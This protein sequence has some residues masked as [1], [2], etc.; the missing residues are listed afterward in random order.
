MPLEA[1]ARKVRRIALIV[2]L[3]TAASQ[4]ALTQKS[5]VTGAWTVTINDGLKVGLRALRL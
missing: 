4:A 5:D 2:A 1:Y 3:C